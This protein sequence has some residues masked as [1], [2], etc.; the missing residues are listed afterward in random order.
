MSAYPWAD[1][2]AESVLCTFYASIE[3]RV[4]QPADLILLQRVF[5]DALASAEE[6]G[7]QRGLKSPR[8]TEAFH[9]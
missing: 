1:Q 3:N 5:R 2:V 8:E 6:S 9:D 4:I 7:Y